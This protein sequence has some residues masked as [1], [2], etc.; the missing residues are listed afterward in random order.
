MVTL[1]EKIVF[2]KTCAHFNPKLSGSGNCGINGYAPFDC[3][4][5]GSYKKDVALESISKP[6][7]NAQHDKHCKSCGCAL[8]WEN[9]HIPKHF[10]ASS[11]N[12]EEWPVCKDCMIEHCCRTNCLGCEYG[13]HP[14]CRFLDMKRHYM[15]DEAETEGAEHEG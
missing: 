2:A 7:D 4:S 1:S 3:A 11:C 9:P 13:Q 8:V 15:S 5:C 6:E 12:L 10:H 14:D